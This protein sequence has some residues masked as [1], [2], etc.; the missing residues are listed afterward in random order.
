MYTNL[1]STLRAARPT[2]HALRSTPPSPIGWERAGVRAFFLGVLL[3]A[4]G[5]TATTAF[6]QS[7]STDQADYP[8]GGTVYITGG[9]FTPGETVTCQV[10]HI[11]DTGDNNTST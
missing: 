11:P 2:L 8:P 3:L 1:I 4:F 7:V 10:L 6:A 5:A 9:G